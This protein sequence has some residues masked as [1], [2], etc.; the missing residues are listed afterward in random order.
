MGVPGTLLLGEE[1]LQCTAVDSRCPLLLQPGETLP[2]GVEVGAVL[3][4]C[5]LHFGM[6]GANLLA[7]A[8]RLKALEREM[9]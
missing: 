6:F 2:G 1:C 7:L 9:A 4:E 8:R 3:A 5:G